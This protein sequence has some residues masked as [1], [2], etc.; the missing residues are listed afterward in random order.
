[1]GT[2]KIRTSRYK[3]STNG[4]VK[5]L[6]RP[7]NAMLGLMVYESQRDPMVMAAYWASRHKATGYSPNFV[8]YGREVR[9]SIELVME[10][11]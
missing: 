9:A 1:M 8:M 11:T 7:L 6:H 4:D 3:A 10:V 5:R 2:D